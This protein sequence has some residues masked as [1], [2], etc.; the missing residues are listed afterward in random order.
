M[1]LKLENIEHKNTIEALEVEKD[2]IEQEY[3]VKFDSVYMDQ[4][5]E[6]E[7]FVNSKNGLDQMYIELQK[8]ILDESKQKLSLENE[9]K[10]QQMMKSELE[11]ALKLMDHSL[12]DKQNSIN[13][14]REQL[15]QVKGLNIELNTSLNGFDAE[16]KAIN[17]E[18][19][20]QT[21]KLKVTMT[22]IEQL[23]QSVK[24]RKFI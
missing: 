10:T 7:T 1:K 12:V 16:K 19:E 17:N 20:A 8:K 15:E 24:V 21:E 23:K 13:K 3:K 4:M 18:L 2:K 14:L 11:G 6:R 22:E 5:T 9:L